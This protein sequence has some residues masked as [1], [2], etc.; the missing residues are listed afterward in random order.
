VK[1]ALF[2]TTLLLTLPATAWASEPVAI[3]PLCQDNLITSLNIRNVKAFQDGDYCLKP[4]SKL[5]GKLAQIIRQAGAL[6]RKAMAAA[7]IQKLGKDGK[8]FSLSIKGEQG[9]PFASTEDEMTVFPDWKG[10]PLEPII[11]LHELGHDIVR[12]LTDFEPYQWHLPVTE[13]IADL[14]AI[15]ALGATSGDVHFR[16]PT[17]PV[18]LDMSRILPMDS[19]RVMSDDLGYAG[20]IRKV[21]DCC[22]LHKAERAHN[23][24]FDGVCAW[25]DKE[26]LEMRKGLSNGSRDPMTALGP[27]HPIEVTDCL[28]GN[29][30]S[31]CDSHHF[32]PWINGYLMELQKI[33]GK[34]AL[35]SIFAAVTGAKVPQVS[36][37]CHLQ[38]DAGYMIETRSG[39]YTDVLK[40][41][42]ES[43]P[44]H[45]AELAAIE[46]KYQ[47]ELFMAMDD[48]NTAE[49]ASSYAKSSLYTHFSD[50]SYAHHCGEVNA[51]ADLCRITCK[52]RGSRAS[53]PATALPS[54]N[55][56]ATSLKTLEAAQGKGCAPSG[57]SR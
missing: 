18:C 11:Y 41:L 27:N 44:G 45:E 34:S 55:D 48:L 49:T 53:A 5:P 56:L 32:G 37:D 36:F 57:S 23:L 22:T 40:S 26:L 30:D 17:L 28:S 9:G 38:A 7:G 29:G 25:I 14:F 8:G 39:S 52:R 54:V 51:D 24:H 47:I 33:S 21:T 20:E 43:I 2:F 3:N 15:E 50:Y 6:N 46:K 31:G 19:S 35:L 10:E 4:L 1:T 16:D 13:P 42:R 12:G